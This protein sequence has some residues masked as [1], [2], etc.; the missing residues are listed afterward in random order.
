MADNL[1]RYSLEVGWGGGQQGTKMHPRDEGEWVKYEDAAELVAENKR[2]RSTKSWTQYKAEEVN[3]FER[4]TIAAEARLTAALE[5]LKAVEWRL[6]IGD[7]G[8]PT[9]PKCKQAK[10]H[11]HAPNCALDAVMN[12]GGAT[13]GR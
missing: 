8:Y 11:G 4:R 5:V 2:L 3:E 13:D 7:Y 1:M 10:K 6:L 9:C 12:K